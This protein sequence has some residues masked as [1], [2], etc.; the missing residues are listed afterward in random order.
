MPIPYVSDSPLV[1]IPPADSP[2][3][4]HPTSCSSPQCYSSSRVHNKTQRL[5]EGRTDFNLIIFA[6]ILLS[7]KCL[8]SIFV[9]VEIITLFRNAHVALPPL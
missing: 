1:E 2:A 6:T 7:V 9:F 5:N 3:N 8:F 4:S